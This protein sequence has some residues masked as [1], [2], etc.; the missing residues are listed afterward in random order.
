MSS[1]KSQASR[2]EGDDFD[3]VAFFFESRREVATF[4][5]RIVLGVLAALFARVT[6]F[7]VRAFFAMLRPLFTAG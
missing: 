4:F 6:F 1:A 5:L 2:S 3:A 7:A